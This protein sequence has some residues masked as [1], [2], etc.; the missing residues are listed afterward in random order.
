MEKEIKEEKAAAE[1]A[2]EEIKEEKATEAKPE[3][4]K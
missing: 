3:E 1:R 4:K 2:R